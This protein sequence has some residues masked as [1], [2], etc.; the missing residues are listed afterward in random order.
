[1]ATLP[2]KASDSGGVPPLQTDGTAAQLFDQLLEEAKSLDP[3]LHSVTD[4]ASAE[5]AAIE[6]QRRIDRMQTLLRFLE[7]APVNPRT[8]QDISTKMSTL[9]RVTQGILPTIQ[10]LIEVN[11]YGSDQLLDILRHYLASRQDFA[12]ANE[13]E[14]QPTGR[15]YEEMNDNL[16]DV[17]YLMRKA[18]D[19]ASANASATALREHIAAQKRLQSLL[20]ALTPAPDGNQ[21]LTPAAA[22]ERL[23]TLREELR[24]EAERLH[25]AD[26]YSSP[27]LKSRLQEYLDSLP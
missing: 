22:R 6:L 2:A 17:L 7:K 3:L 9:T 20:N 1:M 23:A 18:Q 26:Y 14:E 24:Q 8:G 16:G 19:P 21:Q 15:L 5:K 10:R 12:G 13:P 11:A 27:D 4:K 25:K